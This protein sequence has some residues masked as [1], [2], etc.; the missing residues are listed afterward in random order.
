[1]LPFL[2]PWQDTSTITEAEI[3]RVVLVRMFIII[4]NV[5]FI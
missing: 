5:I 2:V 4:P 1:V 3:R